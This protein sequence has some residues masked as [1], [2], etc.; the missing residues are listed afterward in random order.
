[1]IARE[2][3]HDLIGLV[4]GPFAKNEGFCLVRGHWVKVQTSG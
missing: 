2:E 1:V 3:R 4:D